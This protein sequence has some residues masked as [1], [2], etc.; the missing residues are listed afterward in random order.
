MASM[1]DLVKG[2]PPPEE[3]PFKNTANTAMVYHNDTLY[4]LMEAAP[5]HKMVLPTLETVGGW[6][7]IGQDR[8]TESRSHSTTDSE[9]PVGE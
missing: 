2:T 1:A 9:I 3:G 5:P 7:G 6:Q 8:R 4:A